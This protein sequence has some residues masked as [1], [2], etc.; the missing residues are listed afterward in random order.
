MENPN[1]LE[2]FVERD[3]DLL[4]LE[5]LHV[6]EAFRSWF[7]QR[8][9]IENAKSL[10]F[11]WASHSLSRPSLGES[12]I[13]LL[14]DSSDKTK[15]AFLVEDKI[16]ATPQPDQ[17]ERY[18]QRGE[19]GV[20]DGHWDEF[21][22]CIVAPKRYLEAVGDAKRYD[23]RISYESIRDWFLTEGGGGSRGQ[24]RARLLENA[25]E[26]NRRG[27]IPVPNAE[28]TA[29]RN[30]YYELVMKE[31]PELRMPKPREVIPAKA[32]WVRFYPSGLP[33]GFR[34]RHKSR[35]GR[36]D[37]EMKGCADRVDQI[38]TINEGVLDDD[39]EILQASKSAAISIAISK[40]DPAAELEGQLG[41]VM[42]AL[43][44]AVRLW[45]VAGRV[46]WPD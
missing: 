12:D 28:M 41:K 29:F 26:Q 44:A 5:E 3:I 21:R 27:Y 23:V 2:T 33:K 25:I 16:D 11:L 19:A 10:R 14:V 15:Y 13:V 35:H 46:T 38:R 24:Y 7:V 39:M 4:I 45:K 6:S 37:L 42:K 30:W 20:V 43:A 32:G 8:A 34:L 1:S 36:V 17:A 40:V 18:R 31:F 22:T 9:G